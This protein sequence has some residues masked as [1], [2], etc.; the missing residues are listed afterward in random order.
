MSEIYR[1]P[2]DFEYPKPSILQRIISRAVSPTWV[3]GIDIS[4]YQ[5][6]EIVM[7][8]P[9]L[10]AA[11][12][13]FVFIQA[14]YG[15]VGVDS[16]FDYLWRAAKD[17]GLWAIPYH[18]FYAIY[19]GYVQADH[20]LRNTD[21]MRNATGI[22]VGMIDVEARDGA[23]IATRIARL[24]N[25][26]TATRSRMHVIIYSSPALWQE[27]T[28]NTRLNAADYG[29]VAHWTSA[30]S[31]SIPIGWTS[32]QTKFWQRGVWT[33]HSWI[34]QPPGVVEDVDVDS[35]M[36][37]MSELSSFLNVLPTPPPPTLEERV[38]S[39]ERR[40]DALEG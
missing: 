6:D 24:N 37:T 39:L 34:T 22:Q 21:A 16:K 17:A 36:G 35:F 40:V 27:L 32:A 18:F 10:Q 20:F 7:S 23:T 3:S 31:P 1:N 38:S 12:W 19:D 28:N 4:R 33:K 14:T 13:Q 26:W 2:R 8:F 30:N 15:S 29:M 11:G 5:T 9:K 25:F